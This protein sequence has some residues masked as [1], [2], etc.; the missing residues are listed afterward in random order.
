MSRHSGTRSR[1]GTCAP[2][3]QDEEVQPAIG[4]KEV[5]KSA[6]EAGEPFMPATQDMQKYGGD[7]GE[8]EWVFDST[9]DYD[10]EGGLVR[11]RWKGYT[12]KDD[13]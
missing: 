4:E 8:A 6:E 7:D 13:T 11:V 9:V 2:W 1:N 3:V 12:A 10:K 5:A